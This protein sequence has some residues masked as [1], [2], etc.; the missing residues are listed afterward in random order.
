MILYSC[1]HA[2]Q[3]KEPATSNLIA[4]N[5]VSWSCN[6]HHMVPAMTCHSCECRPANFLSRCVGVCHQGAGH[7]GWYP[8]QLP[9]CPVFQSVISLITFL[10]LITIGKQTA[11]YWCFC[12][13]SA[14]KLDM[15]E[16][17]FLVRFLLD[18]YT[19]VDLRVLRLQPY[20]KM[21]SVLIVSQNF[22]LRRQDFHVLKD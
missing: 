14:L 3:S 22:Y 12:L 15:Y 6:V 18:K 9:R 5:Q 2:S 1:D 20:V 8:P 17:L 7:K 19:V 13:S 4:H 21:Y 11:F 10:L 16:C